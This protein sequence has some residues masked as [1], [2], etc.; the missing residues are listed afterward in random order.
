MT[1]GFDPGVC[2]DT[3]TKEGFTPLCSEDAC[4]SF[5][6]TPEYQAECKGEAMYFPAPQSACFN[7]ATGEWRYGPPEGIVQACEQLNSQDPNWIVHSCYCCCGGGAGEAAVATP[8]GEAAAGEV[9]AGDEVSGGSVGG[10]GAL[11]WEP[12]TVGLSRGVSAR[13]EPMLRLAYG[14]ERAELV[15][16]PDQVFM[17]ADRSLVRAGSLAPGQALVDPHGD[18]VPLH[19]VERAGGCG[20]VQ[21]IATDTH[22]D[23]STDGHLLALGGVV[24]GDYTLQL[25]LLTAG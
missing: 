5:M 23:G 10:G 15:V 13:E 1:N 2:T 19:A 18:P 9:Q 16:A 20:A 4:A 3:L 11:R 22:C 21:M 14:D 17:L 7:Q 24:A 6:Q 12:V 25:H 8:E